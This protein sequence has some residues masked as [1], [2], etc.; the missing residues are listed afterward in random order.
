MDLSV[1]NRGKQFNATPE[2]ILSTG[3]ICGTGDFQ[4]LPQKGLVNDLASAIK[5]PS[6]VPRAST[7][8]LPDI[9][10]YLTNLS[11]PACPPRSP[12]QT[13][14]IQPTHDRVDSAPIHGNVS[15]LPE[16]DDAIGSGA[17]ARMKQTE[18]PAEGLDDLPPIAFLAEPS[19][20]PVFS[21]RRLPSPI[22]HG[23]SK[24]GHASTS[25]RETFG[26]ARASS[27]VI[28]DTNA[29]SGARRA[30]A[31]ASSQF[32]T[33]SSS[34]PPP[35][36]A[37]VSHV[38]STS[39]STFKLN[40]H[41]SAFPAL[42]FPST[43]R[44]PSVSRHGSIPRDSSA[45]TRAKTGASSHEPAPRYKYTYN[46][47][48]RRPSP[49]EDADNRAG[50]PA[51]IGQRELE[52]AYELELAYVGVLDG[53]PT[54]QFDADAIAARI[55][56][57]RDGTAA[58]ATSMQERWV[59]PCANTAPTA[60]YLT[61]LE[62]TFGAGNPLRGE[63][64]KPTD[65]LRPR[66]V[67]GKSLAKERSPSGSSTAAE[68]PMDVDTDATDEVAGEDSKDG[69]SSRAQRWIAEIQTVVKGKRKPVREDIAS[70][71][72]TLREI[73]DMSA[74]EGS[75]LGNDGS[76]LLKSIR[77]LAQMQDIPFRD[78]F[79]VRGWARRLVK[80]WPAP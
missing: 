71:L 38:P 67:L 9:T 25:V 5:L 34:V 49:L 14:R 53:L 65:S 3:H 6:S 66:K 26:T 12:T 24:R 50:T 11:G 62:E 13:T 36:A 59:L 18:A 48:M 41:R 52:A 10:G 21:T 70:L 58:H 33:N 29:N 17:G 78:E 1:Y 69:G 8:L 20:S 16:E 73:A 77:E 80:H 60:A 35:V 30:P 45:R 22:D 15:A 37:S 31:R 63:G 57:L 55:E 4:S 42:R 43:L 32:A 74:A 7:T 64:A 76:R 68:V 46:S 27:S 79:Q 40:G 54:D 61:L 47:L 51:P 56:G 2:N 19:V 28:R 39:V 75:A 23:T 72:H 44:T